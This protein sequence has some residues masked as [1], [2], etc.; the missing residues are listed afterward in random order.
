LPKVNNHPLGE[1]ST[2]LVTL[3]GRSFFTLPAVLADKQTIEQ[4]DLLR[5]AFWSKE[6]WSNDMWAK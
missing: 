4:T 2:N 1:K 5:A 3:N 6:I